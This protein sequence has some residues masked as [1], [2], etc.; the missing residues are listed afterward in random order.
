[1]K[2][3]VILDHID[4]ERNLALG[5]KLEEYTDAF[6]IGSL[7]LLKHGIA[8]VDSMRKEF[9]RTSIYVETKI[10]D[11]PREM[12]GLACHNGADWISVMAGSRKEVIHAATSK[13]HDMGKKVLLDLIDTPLAGQAALEAASLGVDAL[14][15]TYMGQYRDPQECIEA[16]QMIIGNTALPIFFSGV[17][18]RFLVTLLLEIR[19]SAIIL[20]KVVT[21]HEHPAQEIQFF[22]EALQ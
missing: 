1:M 14:L 15:F 2:I 10:V 19:P 18:Y 4:A 9:P 21:E 13:A 22:K 17:Q 7:P 8:V 6:V 16:W 11:R 3:Y 5:R 12:V 20:G